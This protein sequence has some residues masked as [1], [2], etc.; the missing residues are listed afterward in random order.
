MTGFG[1]IGGAQRL[2]RALGIKSVSPMDSGR[3]M[4]LQGFRVFQHYPDRVSFRCGCANVSFQK[5]A[6]PK[7]VVIA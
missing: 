2:Q 1:D 6:I 7:T 4:L 3:K 5:L